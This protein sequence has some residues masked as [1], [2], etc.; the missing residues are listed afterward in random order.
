MLASHLGFV[1]QNPLPTQAPDPTPPDP[2]AVFELPCHVDAKGD[3]W[4]LLPSRRV[5]RQ[6][7]S[8][9]PVLVQVLSGPESGRLLAPGFSATSLRHFRLEDIARLEAESLLSYLESWS[10]VQS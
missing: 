7:S 8:V 2:D 10:H 5:T 4:L 3:A 6:S 9:R 1:L